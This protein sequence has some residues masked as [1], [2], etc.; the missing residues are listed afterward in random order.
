MPEKIDHQPTFAR[1]EELNNAGNS[2][3][4]IAEILEFE[5]FPLI[6]R[7]KEWSH[8]AVSWCLN[9]RAS[10]PA[11][12]KNPPPAAKPKPTAPPRADVTID[13]HGP[14][15]AADRGLWGLLLHQARPAPE[16]VQPYK[17]A[18]ASVL[19]TAGLNQE[20][21]SAALARL[22]CT[23]LKFVSYSPP[24]LIVHTTLLASF[25]LSGNSLSFHFARHLLKLLQNDERA[26]QIQTAV[27][28]NAAP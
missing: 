22:N 16:K 12:A 23:A 8:H 11:K 13:I 28:E 20:Q 17:L 10:R 24:G 27:E 25:T 26:A 2:F 1:I 5:K 14:Y 19:E 6:G 4:R 3:R 21:M 9:Q 15:T 7:R 18:V